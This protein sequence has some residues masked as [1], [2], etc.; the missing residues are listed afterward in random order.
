MHFLD[1]LFAARRTR[2]NYS[3]SRC[4]EGRRRLTL[5]WLETREVPAT[6]TVTSRKQKVIPHPTMYMT[7]YLAKREMLSARPSLKAPDRNPWHDGHLQSEWREAWSAEHAR[8]G[9]NRRVRRSRR[10]QAQDDRRDGHR[11]AV[12]TE[13]PAQDVCEVLRRARPRVVSR[14][15]RPFGRRITYGHYAQRPHWHSR[16]S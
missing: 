2:R 10:H 1:K 4:P 13:G 6:I 7:M 3:A 12:G 9:E 16:R 8:G 14:D 15:P 5:E 11:R